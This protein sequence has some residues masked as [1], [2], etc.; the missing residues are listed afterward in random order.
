MVIFYLQQVSLLPPVSLLQ[1]RT[2]PVF[3]DMWNSGFATPNLIQLNV[4]MATDFLQYVIGFFK[5]YGYNF[6]FTNY[7]ICILTGNRVPKHIFDHGREHLLP[8]V[9][10]P[11]A[12]YM[13]KINLEEAD[14][15]EDL[16]ANHKPLVIQ[17]PFDLVHNVGKG[18]QEAKLN[19]II[20]LMRCTYEL[21]TNP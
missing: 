21:L 8:P 5:F 13:S 14:E 1:E 9:F 17:D 19:K 12:I 3:I 2:S 16:F 4:P 7:C 20:H 6:D 18:I 11:F 10:K 15:I